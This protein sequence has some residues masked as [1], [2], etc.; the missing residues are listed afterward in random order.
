MRDATA[1]PA[2]IPI[3]ASALESTVDKL[4]AI[5]L[6]FT[7]TESNPGFFTVRRLVVIA[8]C[9]VILKCTRSGA[10]S[11]HLQAE[12]GDESD[13]THLRSFRC[14][15]WPYSK[16]DDRCARWKAELLLGHSASQSAAERVDFYPQTPQ[17]H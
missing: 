8:Q 2:T 6:N 14:L 1:T 13:F 9:G 12:Q 10:C 16:Q 11:P 3:F 4:M 15:H 7:R 17:S 5:V